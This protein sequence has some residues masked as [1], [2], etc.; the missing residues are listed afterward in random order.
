[1]RARRLG[2]LAAAALATAALLYLLRTAFLP[3]VAAGALA[4]LLSG[5]V[6]WLERR[7]HPRPR[8]TLL[9]FLA[10]AAVAALL[11]LALAP[12]IGRE[13]TGLVRQ[14]PE[15]GRGIDRV[16][17]HYDKALARG[18]LA[19]PY[20]R[21][22]DGVLRLVEGRAVGFLQ[23][24]ARGFLNAAPD[25]MSLLIAPWI[26]YFLVRDTPQIRR[27]LFS[28]LPPDWHREMRDWLARVDGVL[29]GFLR[30]QLIV[31]AVVALL[32]WGVM[33]AFGLGY[34]VLVG[35][36]AGITDAVP[37]VG[38]IIGALPAV[39]V[40]STR[41][42]ATAAWVAVAF[43]LIHEAEGSLLEPLLVGEQMGIHPIVLVLA[44]I[45]GG[46]LGGMLGVL[47]AAPLAGMIVATVQ[48]V[49][50]RLLRP[51]PLR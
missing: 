20:R 28:L 33:T 17:G 46:E 19:S 6:R 34:G 9:V 49:S 42:M 40:A 30:G 27:G 10:F 45:A 35:M 3:L 21:A 37:L 51:R 2:K 44:L 24:A 16:L 15:I 12:S 47:V 11:G 4:Y 29:A 14:L 26:A 18:S 1:M 32:A 5:P 48:V 13:A 38:P 36:L 39:L 8:A 7:G 22:A 23:G 50:R 41:S 31:A 43:L 25:L